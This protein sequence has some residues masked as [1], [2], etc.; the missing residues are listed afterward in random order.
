[1]TNILTL[2]KK[3]I[4]LNFK[5]KKKFKDLPT[6]E[7]D[8]YIDNKTY[9]VLKIEGQIS[10]DNLKFIKLQDKNSYKKNHNIYYEMVFKQDPIFKLVI[11][12]I[13]NKP[14]F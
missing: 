11:D 7:G 1:M 4:V 12:Y 10:K 3:I 8:V 9:E 14:R 2:I 6:I 13:R 5:T